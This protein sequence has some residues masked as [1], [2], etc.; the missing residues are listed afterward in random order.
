MDD[1]FVMK[2][3][4]DARNILVVDDEPIIL[5]ALDK[6]LGRFHYRV[7]KAEHAV[8]AM[9]I[10]RE[11][12]V[13][14]II[15]DYQMPMLS[16]LEF[17]QQAR[18]IQPLATRIL[19]TAIQDN[20]TVIQ[21]I[22]DGEIFR[23]IPKPWKGEE[24]I[25]TI[26]NAAQKFDL[27]SKNEALQ[28]ETVAA[29]ERLKNQLEIVQNQK[30][31]LEESIENSVKLSIKMAESFYPLLGER[32]RQ[33]MNLATRLGKEM[34]S[35]EHEMRIL[36][37]AALV[38]EIGLIS[39][40][41][42]VVERWITSPEGI[43]DHDLAALSKYPIMSEELSAYVDGSGEVS[44]VVRQH[45]ENFDGSGFPDRLHGEYTEKLARILRVATFIVGC[46]ASGS[47]LLELL[48]KESGRKFDPDIV[49]AAHRARIFEVD[50]G[51]TQS[52]EVLVQELERG[53][54]LAEPILTNEGT[55]L[56]QKGEKL[57]P[58][59]IKIINNHNNL[60]NISSRISIEA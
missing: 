32:A 5:K 4:E 3:G 40:P 20:E 19:I 49:R 24:L 38:H 15:T 25:A 34:E 39:V 51:S 17:L 28:D 46:G 33:V 9:K 8:D 10:L 50:G 43:G 27:L 2:L 55:L 44:R 31:E 18:E 35:S 53:M 16:G 57:T 45:C 14:V 13:G 54:V 37:I 52:K 41:R 60:S 6:F 21:A 36:R 47:R 22:N 11:T 30:R 7:H 42:G 26:H 59:F 58:A 48:D 1:T 23:F 29:N 56:V 12:R